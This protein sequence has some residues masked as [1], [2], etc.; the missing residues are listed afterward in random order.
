MSPDE[1]IAQEERIE[2]LEQ[3]LLK[4]ARESARAM[5]HVVDRIYILEKQ[6]EHLERELATIPGVQ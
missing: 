6:I 2:K 3:E 4:F 1:E 5:L